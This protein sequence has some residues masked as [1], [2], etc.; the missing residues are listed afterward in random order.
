MAKIYSKWDAIKM[1]QKMKKDLFNDF[2]II[3]SNGVQLVGGK[4]TLPEVED[5]VTSFRS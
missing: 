1:S 2:A 5:I 4:P 3:F